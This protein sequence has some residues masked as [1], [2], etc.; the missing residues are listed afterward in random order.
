MKIAKWLQAAVITTVS[1]LTIGG[2]S[3]ASANVFQ[4][5]DVEQ[6]DFIAVAVEYQ[7]GD[8]KLIIL[9]QISEEGQIRHRDCWRE[10]NAQSANNLVLVNTLLRTFDFTGI[11]RRST[12]SNGYSIRVDNQDLGSDYLLTLVERQ[13]EIVLVA[14]PRP[15]AGRGLKRI[16]VGRTR[17]YAT[18][19]EKIF[20]DPGWRFAKRTY[21]GREL[22]HI[23]LSYGSAEFDSPGSAVTDPIDQPLLPINEPID[24]PIEEYIYESDPQSGIAAPS[25]EETATTNQTPGTSSTSERT[26]PVLAVPVR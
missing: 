17:G 8:H 18:G 1:C 22:G 7:D 10:Q 23:Y 11:C 25:P 5:K 16:P 2:L 14:V 15:W 6:E 21:Q 12:D 24:G 13:N 20:L 19:N 4:E 3:P 9:E 26:V